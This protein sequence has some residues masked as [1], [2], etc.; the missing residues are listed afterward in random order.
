MQGGYLKKIQHPSKNKVADK[1]K[2]F[3][4]ANSKLLKYSKLS[5]RKFKFFNQVFQ[6]K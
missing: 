1:N 2:L 4:A 6:Y 3:K 5:L